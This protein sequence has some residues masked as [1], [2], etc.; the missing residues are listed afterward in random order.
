MVSVKPVRLE[1]IMIGNRKK[2]KWQ[3]ACVLVA[4]LQ[5]LLISCV[6]TRAGTTSLLAD[7]LIAS[8]EPGWPQWRGPR[9]DGISDEKDLLP[10]WPRNGP[11]LLWRIDGL[12]T[13]WS[14]PIITGGRLY[15][16]GDVGDDLVVFAFDLAGK[17]IWQA[18]NGKA[19][20][21]PY[22]GARACCAYS[23]GRVYHMNAH[24]RVVC[25]DAATGGELWA[26][27]VLEQFGGKNITWAVSE[28]LL[29]DG[30]RVI[31]T[32]GGTR[33]LMAALDKR[34]G[35]TVWTT[36][37]LD[38]DCASHCSPILFRYVGH[39]TIANCSS[40]HGFGVDADTGELLWTVPL[41]N[42]HGV[43]VSTPVYGSGRVFFMTPY[44]EHGRQYRLSSDG[45]VISAQHVWTSP[46]D[47]VTGGAVLVDGTLFA[48]G[49][50]DCKWWLGIDWQSG[51]TKYELKDLTTGSAIHADGRLYCLDERG[52]V[53]LLKPGAAGL[54]IVGRFSLVTGRANDA[55]AHPVLLDGRLYLR[56]D[57]SLWCFDVHAQGTVTPHQ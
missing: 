46:V 42:P 10:A 43:N 2:V 51:R 32:P 25:L 50:R 34:T 26:L 7:G 9:R 21:G 23:D 1:T 48:A 20:K 24:G 18:K 6:A 45:N 30:D 56:Y 37:P 38:E 11:K 36:K 27:N 16:T 47:A 29:I 28:C 52:T 44:A 41:R 22:P 40:A 12:G 5:T 54:E 39:R 19:W 15:V 55:W 17:P 4:A 57:D 31:V 53:A 33:A 3:S 35:Q 13:G 8:P 14:S 49:Y